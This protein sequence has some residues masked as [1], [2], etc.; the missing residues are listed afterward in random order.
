MCPD[1]G[2]SGQL[3]EYIFEIM[4]FPNISEILDFLVAN[5]GI[6]DNSMISD[7]FPHAKPLENRKLLSENLIGEKCLG[8]KTRGTNSR[9]K[10]LGGRDAK[11]CQ[12][13]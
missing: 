10:F 9:G 13:F 4:D 5:L 7:R 1:L 8:G 12:D 3:P 11:I 6:P 2:I